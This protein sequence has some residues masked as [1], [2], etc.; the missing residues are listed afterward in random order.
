LSSSVTPEALQSLSPSMN[1]CVVGCGQPELIPMYAR[2][3]ECPYPIYADPSKK[4]YAELGMTRTLSL[5][6]KAPQYMQYSLPS[7][8]VR[9]IY[10][11]I[12]AG[13]D[14]FKGGDYFQVGGE[15]LFDDGEVTW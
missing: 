15:F 4:L 10:Q 14:A 7:A 3:T 9:A 5:G 1:I 11:N 12:K 6:S 13:R 8:I 2:E